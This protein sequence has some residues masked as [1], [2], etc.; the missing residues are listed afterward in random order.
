[1]PP[2]NK[3]YMYLASYS[4]HPCINATWES[5]KWGGWNSAAAV[6][7]F[8]PSQN[9]PLLLFNFIFSPSLTAYNTHKSI[10][11]S[12]GGGFCVFMSLTFNFC[13][14]ASPTFSLPSA[15]YHSF[16]LANKIAAVFFSCPLS[17]SPSEH[18]R[19][20]QKGKV[21]LLVNAWWS[22]MGAISQFRG[23]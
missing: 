18:Q 20:E 19:W 8:S 6:V 11:M 16:C 3:K 4:A 13:A 10:H 12:A 22:L 5:S 17:F 14:Q 23:F 9:P 7:A 15:T 2:N 1:M 21:P